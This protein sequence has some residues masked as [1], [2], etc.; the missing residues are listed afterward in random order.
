MPSRHTR[1]SMFNYWHLLGMD[2]ASHD[3][4]PFID[5]FCDPT[6]AKRISTPTHPVSPSHRSITKDFRGQLG[7]LTPCFTDIVVLGLCYSMPFLLRG[8][9]GK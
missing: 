6:C 4:P 1:T 7:S 5:T 2:G 9:S 8:T 3:P